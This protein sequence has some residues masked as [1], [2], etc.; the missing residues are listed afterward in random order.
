MAVIKD[1]KCMII[2]A[3]PVISKKVFEEFDPA[4]YF[5]ICADAG[6]DTAVQ[7][8][9]RPDLIIGD[10]D[11]SREKLPRDIRTFKLPV[12]KDETDT[13]AA[14]M[15]GFKLGYTSFVL[16]GC[17][18]G[19]RFDHS[20]AN[21]NVLLYIA[22]KGGSGVICEEDTKIFVLHGGR[23]VLTELKGATVSVFPFDGTSCNLTYDGLEYPL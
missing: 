23:L 22:N 14:V 11:S 9:I 12:Q 5:V 6:Y 2:G 18:G 15:V 16:V 8:G 4:A 10:F 1:K 19:T 7:Y 3:A 17:L 21:I 13:M 20:I